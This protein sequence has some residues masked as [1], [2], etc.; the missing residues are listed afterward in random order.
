VL[1][2][3]IYQQ[4][5]YEFGITIVD[6]NTIRY[7]PEMIIDDDVNSFTYGQ[8][9]IK[10]K[11]I[12]LEG[13]S[14][15]SKTYSTI[16][17]I[18]TYCL[19][20]EGNGKKITITRLTYS[21]LKDSVL[22]DFIKILQTEKIYRQS[23]HSRSHPQH[24]NLFGNKIRFVG[25]DDPARFHGPRQD[26]FWCNEILE[27]NQMNEF[28]QMNQRTNEYFIFDYN[29]YFTEHWVYNQVLTRPNV[30]HIKAL[31]LHNPFLPKG[32]RDELLSYEPTE[33]NIKNGTADDFM[34]KV[35]GLGQRGAAKGVIF[36]NVNWIN[37][38]PKVNYQYGLDFGFTNDPSALVKVGIKDNDLFLELLLYE[39]IDNAFAMS[40]L[41]EKMNI[42]KHLPIYAD[43]SDRYNDVEMIKELRNYG[44]SVNKTNKG[45]GINWRIGQMKRYRI[46]IVKNNHYLNTKREQENYKWREINGISIN[47]PID[48]FNHFWDASGYGYLGLS[49]NLLPNIKF[50]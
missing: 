36:Q 37:E 28:N 3:E 13:S 46:N 42:E 30:K 6:E 32:Q 9:I 48:K 40:D 15:S 4:I 12:G 23:D 35:Y 33:E 27:L 45:K 25:L 2:T 34:W 26:L 17:A 29:P 24:Y 20:N 10:K 7:N 1:T 8:K 43:S 21:W 47:E 31:M 19:C 22:E 11:G 50:L 18:I 5:V 38:F 39:P 44:W 49:V 14:G 41:F 16:Q